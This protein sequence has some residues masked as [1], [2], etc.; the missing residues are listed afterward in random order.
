MP[1]TLPALPKFISGFEDII[2]NTDADNQYHAGDI[3]DLLEPILKDESSWD[4]KLSE[5]ER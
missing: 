1:E 3:P 4:S 5:I 2:I